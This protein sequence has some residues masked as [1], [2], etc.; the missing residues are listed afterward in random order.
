MEGQTLRTKVLLMKGV[1]DC[2]VTSDRLEVGYTKS[3]LR[4]NALKNLLINGLKTRKMTVN[5]AAEYNNV[6]ILF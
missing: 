1:C 6:W 4:H 2:P 5:P 3:L